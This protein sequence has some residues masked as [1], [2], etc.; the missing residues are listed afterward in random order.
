MRSSSEIEIIDITEDGGY[1]RYLYR[2][3][4][5]IPFR[6]YRKR[7]EYLEV[8]ITKGFHK[9]L[10]VFNGE[11]VGQIE[12]APADASG[13]PITGNNVIVMNCTWIPR[14]AKGHNFGCKLLTDMV[15]SHKTAAGFATLALEN[16]WSPWMKREQM[17]KLGFKP[18][19]SIRVTH[20][21]KHQGQPFKIHLMWLPAIKN[22]NQPAWNESKL[23]EGLNFCLAHPL[24]RPEKT[25]LGEIFERI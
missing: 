16:H 24:Y 8:A 4:S 25:K 12:Y 20:R 3:L 6:E 13:C 22:V 23:L 11:V 15:E 9:K 2:C 1:E 5:P 21:T 19:T 14:R 7:R 18:L 17:E 10:V